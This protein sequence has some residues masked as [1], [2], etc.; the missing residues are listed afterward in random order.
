MK[1]AG[2]KVPILLKVFIAVM[3]V[4]ITVLLAVQVLPSPKTVAGLIDRYAP[5]YIDGQIHIGKAS[6]S[7]FRHF[8][9]VG[10]SLED[11]DITYPAD[12]Y[13]SLETH[14]AQ[15]RLALMGQGQEADTLASF[16]RFSV[17]MNLFSFARG[18]INIPHAEL[19]SPRIFI[20]RYHDGG[21]NLDIIHLPQSDSTEE[22]G[23][24]KL[25]EIKLGKIGLESHPHIVYTDSRDTIFAMADLKQL[26][27]NGRL[28][29]GKASRTRL[30]I[31]LDS[32]F[33]AGRISADTLAFGLDHLGIIEHRDKMNLRARAKTLI[34]TRAFGRMNIPIDMRGVFSF[35]SDNVPAV[36]IES[37]TAE[38]ASVPVK[39]NAAIRL[40]EDRAT[41]K[42]AVSIEEC[43]MEDVI[44]K[45]LKN[46]MP[47]LKEISTDA[48]V[49]I[50]AACEGDYI[51]ADGK[52]PEF[53][54]KISIPESGIRH[55]NISNTLKI[56]LEA[57]ADN[58]NEGRIAAHIDELAAECD[59]LTLK[60]SGG[61]RD[62]MEEDPLIRIEGK[63]DA[64][65]ARLRTFLPD[66]MD[67]EAAGAIKAQLDGELRMSDLDLYSFSQAQLEG[68][69]EGK[70][71]LVRMPKDSIDMNIGNVC[72][73][74]G[75][76]TKTSKIDSSRTYHLMAVKGSI[77]HADINYGLMKL[78]GKEIAISAMNSTDNKDSEKI[79]RLGGRLGAE[80]L[81]LTDASGMEVEFRKTSNGFQ[82]FPKRDNP[83]V[84]MLTVS[85]RNKHIY[86]KDG[87]NRAILTDADINA[88]A[89]MNTVERRQR[90]RAFI[91]SLAKIYPDVPRDS[92][93]RHSM[94]QR[95]KREIPE[96]MREEDFKKQDINIKL[97]ETM[98]KYFREWDMNGNLDI[99][100]GIVMTPYF[101][102]TNI[103]RGFKVQF[104]NDRIAIDSVKFKSGKS[105]IAGKGA[106]TGLRRALLGRGGMKLDLGITSDKINANEILTAFNS[107]SR[108]TAPETRTGASEA[109]D[110]E[111]LK[112]V[113][114]D[115]VNV[116]DSTTPLLVIP[117]NI[118]ADINIAASNITY[119]DVSI[120]SLTSKLT[121][122]ER[123]VQITG[124]EAASNIGDISFEGFYATRSKKN[125]KAGFSFNFRDITAE[126]VIDLIPAVDS[127]MPMLKSFNGQLNCEVAATAAIDTS[128][129]IITP[130]I[131]GV[132]R[133][134]GTDLSIKDS[135]MYRDL[136]KKLM[137]KNKKEGHINEM[138][139]EGV[140][141]DSVLEVFPFVIK[142]DRYTLALSGI[143]NLDQSFKYHASL[144]KSPFLIRL[145]IDLYGEDFDNMKFKIGKAKYKNT[146]VPVFSAVIDTTKINLVRSIRGIF[147][148]GVEA[149][150]SENE[151]KEAIE[152]HRQEI[153]YIRAVDQKLEALS[154]KEQKQMEAEEAILKEADAAEE[155]LGKAVQQM[156]LT[157]PESP[158][159]KEEKTENTK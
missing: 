113:V 88:T 59:G 13:D 82:M 110:A 24:G 18:K 104:D 152:K 95:Q 116:Q 91:D 49:S 67:I 52:L 151:Q 29:T 132:M 42:A 149:A 62:L 50:S 145:G 144:L 92:L 143:Q 86:Y 119:S 111:Y 117:S 98:A 27:L 158:E 69:I 156:T 99:R 55:K 126:K 133:I 124:T 87:I 17:S 77:D 120:N 5:E 34:A 123:C 41:V 9:N 8:P 20:H 66:T 31:S 43:K 58:R 32:L 89:A 11:F 114:K 148:K 136:A 142:L 107:G 115:T 15:G 7:L 153:G 40:L 75:P 10:L 121:M 118:N 33:V 155:A 129:N 150:I 38:I 68:S 53:T 48:S 56:K 105:E 135:E 154:E 57:S 108:F 83:E 2:N 6:L 90:A 72:V 130:S 157:T 147:E 4:W 12:R 36:D 14:G 85:S 54:A 106:L 51:F 93:M 3:A 100:T 28:N 73:T 71:L 141:S 137:F 84:P 112:M 44:E 22:N 47:Q 23:G 1:E 30:G 70:E 96:W 37:L 125:I 74:I 103:I 21:S 60:G 63:L 46:Y 45:F 94:A 146:D 159:K 79:G 128:M 39:A 80:N 64:D 76:E 25:P 140:I 139:V 97:D 35:P 122:K 138:S 78:S 26:R 109:T 61:M 127:I 134:G 81:T 65:L 101:P 102:L 131:N 19:I 16:R